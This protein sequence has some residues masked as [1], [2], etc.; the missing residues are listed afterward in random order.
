MLENEELTIKYSDLPQNVRDR[1]EYLDSLSYLQ[2]L[3]YDSYQ[4]SDEEYKEDAQAYYNACQKEMEKILYQCIEKEEPQ[5]E[6]EL[7]KEQ[8][9]WQE[10]FER[11]IQ[12]TQAI[13][14]CDSM[15][16]LLNTNGKYLYF[17]Y[18]DMM[19]RRTLRLLD[20]YFECN[21][22]EQ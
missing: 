22:Y 8:Q 15:E 12:D 13:Y 1:Q 2:E 11:R 19:L 9:L 17:S 14:G 10:N 6:T 16:E 7:E 4:K 21:E 3:T 5:G 20:R 18:G